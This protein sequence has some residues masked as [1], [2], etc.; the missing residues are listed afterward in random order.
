M[1]PAHFVFLE[2]FPLTFNGKLDVAALERLAPHVQPRPSQADDQPLSVKQRLTRIWSD[3][4]M[5]P[6]VHPMRSFCPGGSSLLIVNLTRTLN[7]AFGLN[8]QV[9]ELFEENSIDA[10]TRLIG[11]K[12]GL[13]DASP[14]KLGP[15]SSM[16]RRNAAI[17]SAAR[18]RQKQL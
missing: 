7:D 17:K 11:R 14:S 13:D 16:S 10:Q 12:L 4:L 18:K 6:S 9:T 15:S 1:I 8:L 2:R 5:T 3:I